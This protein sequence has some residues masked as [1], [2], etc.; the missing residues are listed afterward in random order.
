[1]NEI[2][3]ELHMYLFLKKSE[4]STYV[5]S[6]TILFMLYYIL[7]ISEITTTIFNSLLSIWMKWKS[8][9]LKSTKNHAIKRYYKIY[10]EN[11][12]RLI[13]NILHFKR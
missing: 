7:S 13:I 10:Q 4:S 6:E 8:A 11:L 12:L 2:L 9:L 5:Y 3:I 1:M